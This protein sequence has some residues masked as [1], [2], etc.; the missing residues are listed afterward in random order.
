MN[1]DTAHSLYTTND[2]GVNEVALGEV[3]RRIHRLI[4][5]EWPSKISAILDDREKGAVSALTYTL[6]RTGLVLRQIKTI[7]T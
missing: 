1:E 7:Y 6:R 3:S 2:R 4:T 5:K